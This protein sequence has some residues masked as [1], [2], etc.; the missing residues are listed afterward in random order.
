MAPTWFLL[1]TCLGH[2]GWR[3]VKTRT[4]FMLLLVVPF[5]A[6]S[7][8]FPP[9][10]IS[11]E[12]PQAEEPKYVGAFTCRVCHLEIYERWLD[13]PY[14]KSLDRLL[15]GVSAKEKQ[16]GGLDP[17]KDYSKDPAC[18]PCH[19]T[20]YGKPSGYTS[21]EET[22]LLA[23][24]GCEACHQPGSVFVKEMRLVHK[25]TKEKDSALL[26]QL[27]LRKADETTCTPCH[28]A[29]GNVLHKPFSFKDA[30]TQVH[31]EKTKKKKK[32]KRKKRKK[33]KKKKKS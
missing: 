22:P 26:H 6:T 14:A 28:K 9:S 7:L 17:D 25:G 16:A 5:L 8:L 33:R 20:G 1:H 29:E 32:K 19:T 15:P 13:S 30:K 10:G 4:N 23:N 21:K 12:S 24:V 27:G 18:L 31:Q 2:D 11:Q 3:P